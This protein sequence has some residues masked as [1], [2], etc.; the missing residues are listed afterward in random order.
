MPGSFYQRALSGTNRVTTSSPSHLKEGDSY[1]QKSAPHDPI[2]PITP[3]LTVGTKF[4]H[5]VCG[6]KY[7]NYI[8]IYIMLYNNIYAILMYNLQIH[9]QILSTH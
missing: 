3:P 7:P 4:Q 1:T 8:I 5:E 2:T 6:N 9:L